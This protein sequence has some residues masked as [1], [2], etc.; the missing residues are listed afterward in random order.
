MLNQVYTKKNPRTEVKKLLKE[1]L[2]LNY[3]ESVKE[4][5]RM[6]VEKR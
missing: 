6:F 2:Y 3:E 1:L 5:N 4:F